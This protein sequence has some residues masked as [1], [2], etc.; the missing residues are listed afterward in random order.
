MGP[1][2]L[3]LILLGTVTYVVTVPA[4]LFFMGS[5]IVSNF[6]ESLL[7]DN[8]G[9]PLFVLF[10]VLVLANEIFLTKVIPLVVRK[11]RESKK[12]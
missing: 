1:D 12:R 7:G 5:D 6:L 4:Y 9:W 8:G 3:K 10:P 11:K 2:T